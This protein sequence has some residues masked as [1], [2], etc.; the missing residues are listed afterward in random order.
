ME[1]PSRGDPKTIK[2]AQ[3][4]LFHSVVEA[5]PAHYVRGQYDGYR[6]IDG[7]A[8]GLGHGDLRRPAPRHRE[9]AMVRRPLLHPHRQA[10][11]GDPDRAAAGV[12][13]PSARWASGSWG[14]RRGQPGRRQAGPVDRDQ[15]GPRRA[16]GGH[17]R[18]RQ[19][20]AGHGVR[21]ARA[22]RGRRRTRCCCTPPWSGTAR[23][24]PGRTGW[25]RPGG[26]CSRCS[27]RHHPSTRTQPGSWGPAE[28]D[29]ADRGVRRLAPARGWRH[30][31]RGA[32]ERGSALPVP[33]HRRLR[34]PVQ[35]PH[36]RPGRARRRDRLALRPPLRLAQRLRDPARPSG[37]LLP[38]R[39]LRDQPPDSA[40]IRA[41]I[42][43]PDDDLEDTVGL[44][45]GP[46]RADHGSARGDDE[47]TPH[48]R[49][50]A[51]DDADH[52][53][54]RTVRCLEG[55]VEIELVCEPA[56]DYGR[57]PAEWTLVEGNR[58][59]ADATGAGQTIRLQT[60][61]ALGV[62]G[63]RVRARH[64]LS[65]GEEC[66]CAL[67]W[68][69]GWPRR[70][71]SPRPAPPGRHHAV[72]ARLAGTGADARPPVARPDP[73]LGPGHQGPHL[74]ADRGNRGGAHD[75][76]AGDAGRRAQLGLPLHLDARHHLHA[77]GPA[78]PEPGLGG[79]RV[80]AV[81]RRP[82]ADRDRR[83]PDHVRHRRPARPDGVHPRRP[84]RLRGRPTR[85]DR[86]R[87]VRPAPERRV[88]RRPGLHPAAHPTQPTPAA[89]A[90]ADRAV[91]GPSAPP[92]CGANPTRASGRP[93]A[94]PSTTC[95]PS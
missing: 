30:D 52:M 22:E 25:R 87:S 26:S 72:L 50:P 45:R 93:A 90:V 41:G 39:T 68:A 58:H 15:V 7:V 42:Q 88:R 32:P 56:F 80:H 59:A 67:S 82:R 70:P 9:L 76:A 18:G 63:N 62:E 54:V 46:R 29:A 60:D 79:G 78:L 31:R 91:A 53:L 83:T 71:T 5:D 61:L 27:T 28:A 73:A 64:V 57:T 74:H 35:L 17:L 55:T 13:A 49:P 75:L 2:D 10:T 86:Q 47:V 20:R 85:A 38:V 3:V 77:A 69:E 11:A 8:A 12:Q 6:G 81:R 66:Y 65:A 92:R 89:A 95:P 36:R 23:A 16:A 33:A 37:G 21:R 40:G 51:D 14:A 24:S 4:A 19:D 1:A 34:V 94:S 48:T 44:D 84:V 43:R